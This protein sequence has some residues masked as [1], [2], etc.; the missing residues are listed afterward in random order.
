MHL[1]SILIFFSSPLLES[2]WG[3]M[4][5]FNVLPN[6]VW[7][8]CVFN[9]STCH[10]RFFPLCA[11]CATKPKTIK[12]EWKTNKCLIKT[13]YEEIA[14]N[15]VWRYCV[16]IA[17]RYLCIR[18]VTVNWFLFLSKCDLWSGEG[19]S[20]AATTMMLE[21]TL[22]HVNTVYLHITLSTHPLFLWTEVDVN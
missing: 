1:E 17:T 3:K 10:N 11:E 8:W 16:A 7:L 4:V 20:R 13:H 6:G 18:L 14:S 22:W 21:H 2:I 19:M 5:R 15:L 9:S 12:S